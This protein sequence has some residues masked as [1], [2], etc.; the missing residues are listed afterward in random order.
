MN[1][2]RTDSDH[3]G[4]DRTLVK[5]ERLLLDT[6]VVLSKSVGTMP[7]TDRDE[8]TT[9]AIVIA[10]TPSVFCISLMFIVFNPCLV[11]Y[12]A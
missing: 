12:P 10:S 6:G 5:F 9:T 8:I 3:W 7:K 11:I 2:K 4:R 1:V